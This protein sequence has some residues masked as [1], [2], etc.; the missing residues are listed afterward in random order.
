M[1]YCHQQRVTRLFEMGGNRG[2]DFFMWG[3]GGTRA[4]RVNTTYGEMLPAFTFPNI[5]PTIGPLFLI[6][7][8]KTLEPLKA[9]TAKRASEIILNLGWLLSFC[10]SL[11]GYIGRIEVPLVGL[12]NVITPSVLTIPTI[13][14]PNQTESFAKTKSSFYCLFCKKTLLVFRA[15]INT[16]NF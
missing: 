7:L 1:L 13:S 10:S 3:G 16:S 15:Q 9:R 2:S 4:K 12:R 6:T 11:T 8:S 5:S 14:P